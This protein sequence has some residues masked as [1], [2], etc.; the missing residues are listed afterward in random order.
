VTRAERV[1]LHMTEDSVTVDAFPTPV[2]GLLIHQAPN[3][4]GD[5]WSVTH[6]ASGSAVNSYLPSPE[7]ALGCA[8]DLGRVADWTQ[9]I[10]VLRGIPLGVG[11]ILWRWGAGRCPD[12]QLKAG[13]R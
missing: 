8:I 3:Q 9:P 11:E 4:P 10:G 6:A 2:P 12:R 7:A 1:T 13:A 5:W